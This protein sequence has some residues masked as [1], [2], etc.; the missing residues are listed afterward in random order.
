MPDRLPFHLDKDQVRHAFHRAAPRYDEAAVLQREVGNRMLE[1]LELIR[2]DPQMIVDVGCGTGVATAALLK[3]YRRARVIGLD[4]APAMLPI[5]RRRAPWLRT[6]HCVCADA[7]A[8]PLADASCDMIFSN[9]TLQWCA[10]LDRVFRECRRALKPG[11]LL[12]F[13]TLGPDTLTE[14][15]QS[16]AQADGYN[17]VNAF[18]DM[19][20]VGDALVRARLADPVM[21]VERL[22]L[23]YADVYALMRDLKT[24]GAHNVT[25]GRARGLT[26]RRRLEAMGAAYEAF[27][28][29]DGRLPATFEVVY[30]H[31]W[32]SE[33]PASLSHRRA[34]GAAVFP[35]A[36]LGRTQRRR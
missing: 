27:R 24:L 13:S 16:W 1:R 9:L 25:A 15:R 35:L 11:G 8:L 26:G 22:T 21:D 30:G 6:L 4:I 2:I 20:D 28:D 29:R 34:D 31:A 19:H 5:A 18:I 7:E 10:D 32:G 23:T 36:G 14:L 12:L 33:S 17:H 3:R